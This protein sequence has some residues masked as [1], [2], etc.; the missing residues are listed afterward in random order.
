MDKKTVLNQYTDKKDKMLLSLVY[1]RIESSEKKNYCIFSDFLD[2]TQMTKVK[3]AFSFLKDEL[4]FSSKIENSQTSLVSLR[5]DYY[6]IPTDIIEIKFPKNCSVKHS[7]I[8]GSI[9]SL[10]IKRQ[11]IGDIIVNNESCFIEVKEEITDFLINNLTS[12][13]TYPVE[14]SILNDERKIV[15]TQQYEDFSYT[16]SSLRLDCVVS[17]ILNFSREKSKQY[18]LFGNVKV[19]HTEEKNNKR[20]ISE[21]DILSLKK[22]GRYLFSAEEGLSKKGK[23]KITIKKYI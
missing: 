4:M 9:M 17:S 20:L 23:Y 22:S 15:R 8:L 1:D 21:G 11:K 6:E 19:N 10:G 5:F 3:N 14:L 12:V 18:I 16:V 13:R 7:D 2:Q